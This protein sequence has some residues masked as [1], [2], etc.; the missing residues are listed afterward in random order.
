MNGWF[1]N[2][3]SCHFWP[4]WSNPSYTQHCTITHTHTLVKFPPVF[5][6]IDIYTVHADRRSCSHFTFIHSSEHTHTHSIWDEW[7]GGSMVFE[8]F[9]DDQE[10]Y[11]KLTHL[12]TH[13][14]TQVTAALTPQT[15]VFIY[16]HYCFINNNFC[17]IIM[18][19][20]FSVCVLHDL[21]CVCLIIII[22]ILRDEDV[23]LLQQSS[24]GFTDLSPDVQ[25]GDDDHGDP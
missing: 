22:V 1:L 16:I 3:T 17:T 12:Y 24:E 6:F 7:S 8:I 19:R 21:T 14:H 11:R 5:W 9:F 13:T 23:M 20:W 15:S 2:S 25:E 18:C 10:K 4:L